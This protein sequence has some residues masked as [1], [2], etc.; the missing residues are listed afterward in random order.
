M[1]RMQ[2]YF[3]HVVLTTS[4]PNLSFEVLP[5]DVW[6]CHI[7]E[8]LYFNKVSTSPPTS[9]IQLST[10]IFRTKHLAV[11]R[12]SALS[13]TRSFPLRRGWEKHYESG[14]AHPAGFA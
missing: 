5:K 9:D 2:V 11:R 8:V 1:Q 6:K 7:P 13:P 12:K 10:H 4:A 3:G 14:K